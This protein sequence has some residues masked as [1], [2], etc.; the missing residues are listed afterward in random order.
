MNG[1]LKILFCC[2]L[3]ERLKSLKLFGQIGCL[4]IYTDESIG[5]LKKDMYGIIFANVPTE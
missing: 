3:S 5:K 1:E 2:R 4:K